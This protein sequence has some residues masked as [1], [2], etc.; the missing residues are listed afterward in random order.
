MTASAVIS[1]RRTLDRQG[2][3]SGAVPGVDPKVDAGVDPADPVVALLDGG[4]D[5]AE[6]VDVAL[7]A[8][9]RRGA[10]LRVV[11]V[12]VVN[13]AEPTPFEDACAR[14]YVGGA[15]E[16]ARL[17]P[18]VI[19]SATCLTGHAAEALTIELAQASTLVLSAEVARDI[20]LGVAGAVEAERCEVRS[21]AGAPRRSDRLRFGYRL[22]LEREL[23]FTGARGDGSATP[24]DLDDAWHVGVACP[25]LRPETI[26]AWTVC[27]TWPPVS[28]CT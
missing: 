2:A 8:C 1:S 21:V 10:Q 25:P 15:I 11:H 13:G 12:G 5:D 20:R 7:E 19:A 27:S 3:G 18:G 23:A 22:A 14:S 4:P 6:V 24:E 9:V 28:Q 16:V 26:E 17:V